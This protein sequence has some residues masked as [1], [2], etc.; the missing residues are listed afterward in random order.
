MFLNH[1]YP[2]PFGDSNNSFGAGV[3]FKNPPVL[4]EAGRNKGGY[5]CYFNDFDGFPLELVQPPNEFAKE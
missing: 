2:F 4:I 1:K 5:T 3:K